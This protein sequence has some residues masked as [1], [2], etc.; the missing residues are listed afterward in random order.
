M[1]RNG[2]CWI[3]ACLV[4]LV[5]G[6][7]VHAPAEA[8]EVPAA[9]IPSGSGA[10]AATS[11]GLRA[12]RG[13]QPSDSALDAK[14]FVD[15]NGNGAP[16]FVE[17]SAGL[18]ASS[19]DGCLVHACPIPE[20]KEAGA[21]TR[22]NLLFVVDA[23]GSMAALAGSER[24]FEAARRTLV[25]HAR[26]LPTDVRAGLLVY[27]HE[28]DNTE[29]GR[30]ISCR[31]ATLLAPLGEFDAQR[32]QHAA[33]GIRA[34][35]WTPIGLALQRA[36]AAFKGHEAEDNH[37]LLISDGLETCG[38]DAVAEVGKLRDA[39]IRF[40]LDVVGFDIARG[41]DAELRRIAK[42]GLGEYFAAGDGQALSKLFEMQLESLRDRREDL[43]NATRCNADSAFAYARCLTKV[44]VGLSDAKKA[45]YGSASSADR[46]RL[47]D[48]MEA[49]QEHAQNL[50][51]TTLKRLQRAAEDAAA[52][53]REQ[54]EHVIDAQR[55]K[56][57]R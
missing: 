26:Q 15:T 10:F 4:T 33:D 46:E 31:S 55:R 12:D 23:S 48:A 1:A 44:T 35:G 3:A 20:G 51:E 32:A 27:G 16:D 47:D 41:E 14:W 54:N 30:A 57:D 38:G 56:Q 19:E 45:A 11:A 53:T 13:P 49:W 6:C 18:D 36:G 24:K 28:G 52:A 39:G 42:A 21:P 40:R 37:I 7:T 2:S 25:A 22:R 8:S 9:G 5:A 43:W 29:S 17:M 50:R 34:V